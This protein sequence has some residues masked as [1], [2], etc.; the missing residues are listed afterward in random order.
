MISVCSS[1]GADG[2]LDSEPDGSYRSRNKTSL[3]IS[4]DSAHNNIGKLTS[5]EAEILPHEEL[6]GDP[7]TTVPVSHRCAKSPRVTSM[8]RT[9]IAS[10][11]TVHIVRCEVPIKEK[12]LEKESAKNRLTEKRRKMLRQQQ[13]NILRAIRSSSRRERP[14]NL[15][16]QGIGTREWG[17]SRQANAIYNL[18]SMSVAAQ[19]LTAT[20][21]SANQWNRKPTDSQPGKP[22]KS[23]ETHPAALLAQIADNS[24]LDMAIHNDGPHLLL[25]TSHWQQ[26]LPSPYL[27]DPGSPKDDSEFENSSLGEA[28]PS[29][30]EHD[31][32][33]ESESCGN[34]TGKH[35]ENEHTRRRNTMRCMAC[36]HQEKPKL[37]FLHYFTKILHYFTKNLHYFA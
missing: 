33:P 37:Y 11:E 21:D 20:L 12:V 8:E 30:H 1:E 27:P 9:R 3:I 19:T 36:Q 34:W 35:R 7:W 29:P 26:K 28:V 10:N 18:E 15:K 24:C 22:A 6:E 16:R 25:V 5:N 13:K 17:Q 4:M 23:H 32:A 14:S 31:E 2:P